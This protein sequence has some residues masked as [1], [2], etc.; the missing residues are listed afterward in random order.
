MLPV[1]NRQTIET[2]M[3]LGPVLLC[4]ILGRGHRL[5]GVYQER[6]EWLDSE[7]KHKGFPVTT[8]FVP[9]AT[10]SLFT[11]STIPVKA[12]AYLKPSKEEGGVWLT[13]PD[14][15]YK[16]GSSKELAAWAAEDVIR[17]LGLFQP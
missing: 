3:K 17:R 15:I 13:P 7:L 9:S 11:D 2:S 5:F 14:S 1:A 4:P 6:G 8:L 12:W 16:R 10:L